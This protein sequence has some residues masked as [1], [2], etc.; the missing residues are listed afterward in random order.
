M[1]AI[2][3]IWRVYACCCDACGIRKPEKGYL[4]MDMKSTCLCCYSST[5]VCICYLCVCSCGGWG[6]ICVCVCMCVFVRI[7]VCTCERFNLQPYCFRAPIVNVQVWEETCGVAV[8]C[9]DSQRVHIGCVFL[10]LRCTPCGNHLIDDILHGW[11]DFR[12]VHI[13]SVFL[14]LRCT[15]F[16]ITSLSFLTLIRI[17]A[18]HRNISRDWHYTLVQC[19]FKPQPLCGYQE[20]SCR[21]GDLKYS[22]GESVGTCTKTCLCFEGGGVFECCICAGSKGSCVGLQNF[23]YYNENHLI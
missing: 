4:S 1:I 16:G 11:G 23:T 5:A 14:I 9:S 10:I 18:F 12:S 13:G 7:C 17:S 6:T 19:E 2:I 21:Y 3:C 22:G 8:G 15:P 20:G